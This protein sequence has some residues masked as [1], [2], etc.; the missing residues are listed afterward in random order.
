MQPLTPEGQKIINDLA[1]QYQISVDAVMSMLQALM[2]GRG[3]MA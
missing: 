2:D 1:R 3:S